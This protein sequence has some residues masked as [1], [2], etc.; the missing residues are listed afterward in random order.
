MPGPAA[1]SMPKP[2]EALRADGKLKG[3]PTAAQAPAGRR[4]PRGDRRLRERLRR[5][6]EARWHVLPGDVGLV[7]RSRKGEE[8]GTLLWPEPAGAGGDDD[9]A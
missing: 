4:R 9:D 3:A 1:G 7:A 6:T 5:L 2:A 8:L